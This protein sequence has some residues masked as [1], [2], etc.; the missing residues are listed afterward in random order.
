MASKP[1]KMHKKMAAQG[2]TTIQGNNRL[3]DCYKHE[4]IKEEETGISSPTS[5][6]S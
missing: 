3:S 1:K 6:I 4:I 5:N 2:G